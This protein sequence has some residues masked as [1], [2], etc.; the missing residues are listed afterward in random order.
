MVQS[1]QINLANLLRFVPEKGQIWLKDYRMV[2]LSAAALGC[3]RKE[4]IETVGTDEARALMKRFGHAAGVADDRAL[5]ERFPEA[6]PDQHMAYGPALHSLEGV[7]RVIRDESRSEIDLDRGRYHTEAYWENSYEAEQH[8]QLFGKS[9]QPVCWTLVGYATGHSSSAAGRDTVVVETECMAMG[10]ERCRFVIGFAD[11]MPEAA[12]R[13]NPDYQPHHLSEVLDQLLGTI[14]KQ[15]QTLRTKERAISRL[16]SKVEER[17][18]DGGI[19]GTSPAIRKAIGLGKVVAPVDTTVL[20]LGESGTGKELLARMIHEG[21]ARAKKPFVAVNCS[22]L[23]ENLQ[24]AELF[25][26]TKGAFT[27]AVN[28]SQGL[29]E[30]ADG[31]T[32]FLDEIGDLSWSAQTKILRALQEGEIKRLGE[33]QVRKVDVRVLA[34]THRDLEAM[35]RSRDFREDLY[36]R[37][38]VVTITLPPLRERGDDP[39]LLARHFARVYARQF[40]KEVRGLTRATKCA[41]AS[42]RWPGNVRELQNAIQRGVILTQGDEVELE[43]LPESVITGARRAESEPRAIAQPGAG[44]G[45]GDDD[46]ILRD[47]GDEEERIRRALELAEGNRERAAS[48]LG[49]SRTTLWRRMRA[50]EA[51]KEAGEP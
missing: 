33:T 22:A 26:F 8:L 45:Q 29:F 42:Y 49:M 37:L 31:G 6:T 30:A 40:S 41:V 17:R 43:D 5:V 15:K 34:A 1:P 35:M 10:H 2:M 13:E 3:L 25:G 28:D 51:S 46:A 50:V 27:G 48:M 24:E 39:L 11:E 23:P 44:P 21:S 16:R 4:L 36:Y 20:I 14:K 47:I 32:L 12:R 7:A 9:D 38:S 18:A 19:L